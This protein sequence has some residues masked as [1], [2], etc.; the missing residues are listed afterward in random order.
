MEQWI[1]WEPA[2]GLSSKYS[3]EST[4]F[5]DNG[6]K[7]ILCDEL[8]QTKKIS[9]VFDGIIGSYKLTDETYKIETWAFLDKQYG[10]NFYSK[11]TFFK[12]SNSS[13]LRMLSEES[14]GI[15]DSRN[16]IHFVI[17]EVNVVLEIVASYE[18]KVELVE[19]K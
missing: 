2:R 7:I 15:A 9:L 12:V 4:I 1:R 11:W 5:D 16:L 14:S 18:P 13:Y 19:E 6:L 10:A 3:I 17:I 8:D